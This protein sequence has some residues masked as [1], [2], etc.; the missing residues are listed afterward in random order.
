MNARLLFVSKGEASSSTRYRA[1]QFFPLWRAAGFEPAH[2]TASGGLRATLDMLRQAR[3]ADVVIVLRK[4]FPA[5]LLWLLRRA[6]RRLVFDFDDAI[7]CN[8]DGTPSRTRMARFAA[9][10]RACDHV[11]AGNAFLAGNAAAFN[12]AVTLVPTCL[13]AARYRVEAVKPAETLDLVWIGSRSTR[14]YLAE[15]MPWLAAAA[16]RLPQL[17]LKIV[18][19]FDLP[20]CGVRTLPVAWRAESEAQELAASHI[21]I[22]P[23][24]DDDWSRGKCALKVLQCMAAGLPVVSSKAGA[25]AEVIEDGVHGFLAATPEE[26]AERIAQLAGD[27]ELRRQMGEA[28]RRRVEADFSVEAVFDRLRTA[29]ASQR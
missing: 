21:G 20:D 13:D 29:I 18:A 17:R 9:M 3:R 6:A 2:V 5:I 11:L 16:Q 10:A 27:A 4:T 24:R 15:A 23:M 26:W 7:F 19:D 25:N 12:P 14:K 28:G 1:L 22:A 8:T